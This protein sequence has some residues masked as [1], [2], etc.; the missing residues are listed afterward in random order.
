MIL[1]LWPACSCAHLARVFEDL[2]IFRMFGASLREQMYRSMC[3][4]KGK[5]WLVDRLNAA[6][7]FSSRALAPWV[8]FALATAST[9]YW[10]FSFS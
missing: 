7:I 3:F 5:V 9:T 6:A 2:P 8:F 4:E 10:E 1:K